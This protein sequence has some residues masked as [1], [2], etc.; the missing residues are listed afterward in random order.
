M[1][2]INSVQ[3]ASEKA[4]RKGVTIPW[5]NA[6]AVFQNIL[7]Q[8]NAEV[9]KEIIFRCDE[10]PLLQGTEDDIQ[11]IFSDLLQMILQ[12]RNSVSQLFLHINCKP[13]LQ[14]T[15]SMTSRMQY[16]ILFSTN[17]TPC[18]DWM[19]TNKKQIDKMK[20]ILQQYNGSL[21]IADSQGCI[22]SLSLPGKTQ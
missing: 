12:K 14:D 1:S 6:N 16:I 7:Q 11:T 3:S 13:L 18:T 15:V 5:V 2:D 19:H 9:R 21:S 4:G 20:T 10:L 8:L 22:F 17:I